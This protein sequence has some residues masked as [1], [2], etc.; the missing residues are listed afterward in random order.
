M[1]I[2]LAALRHHVTGAIERGDAVAIVA[3]DTIT[4]NCELTD[5]FAGEANYSWVRRATVTLPAD[6]SQRSIVRAVNQALRIDSRVNTESDG[7]GYTLRVR[8]AC[9]VAFAHPRQGGAA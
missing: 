7:D 6:A 3:R 9:M 2:A 8:G 1:N 5:T 4:W